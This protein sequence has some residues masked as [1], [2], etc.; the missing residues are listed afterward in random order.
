MIHSEKQI[1]RK[2]AQFTDKLVGQHIMYQYHSQTKQ[3]GQQTHTSH[4][5]QTVLGA[6]ELVLHKLLARLQ[7]VD[8]GKRELISIDNGI[9]D[10]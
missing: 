5:L 1:D 7:G 2:T 6:G 10:V 3:Q 4:L 8:L 9:G